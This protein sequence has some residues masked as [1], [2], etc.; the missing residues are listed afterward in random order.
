MPGHEATFVAW[1][2]IRSKNSGYIL[3]AIYNSVYFYKLISDLY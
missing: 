1:H 2:F 3:I